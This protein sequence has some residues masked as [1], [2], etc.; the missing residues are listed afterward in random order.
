ML[1]VTLIRL[2][3]V[4]LLEDLPT[5]NLKRGRGQA[6]T[7]I[8]GVKFTTA[9]CVSHAHVPLWASVDDIAADFVTMDA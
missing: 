1:K 3:I 8:Y 9:Y 6:L 2:D 4:A 7:N 5:Q